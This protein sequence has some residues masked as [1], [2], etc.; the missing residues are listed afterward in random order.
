MFDEYFNPPTIAVSPVPVAAAPRAVDLADSPVSTSI[1]K[2]APSTTIPSIQDQEHSPIISQELKNFKQ[3]MIE[4]SWIDAMQE[5]IHEFERLQVWELVSCPDKVMLIKLKWIYKV[6]TDKF[7]WVLKNK[8]RLVAQGFRQEEGI[9]FEESFSSVAR[10]EAICI[11]VANADNKNMTI[12]QMDVKTAFLNGELKEEVYVSQPEGFIE[13]DNPSHVYKLKKALYGLKQAP[14]AWYDMLSSFLIS[15]HFSKGVVDLTLFTRKAGNDLLLVQIYVDIIIFASTNTAM[16][17]EFANLMTT[18]FKMS[19]IGQMSF[20]LGL[21]ISQS[22]RGIF[23]NQSKYASEI[24]KKYGMLT[25][26]SVDTPM[27]KPTEKHLNAVKQ[28]FRYLKGSINMGLLYL[29]DIGISLTA[30]V[31][32]DHARCQDTRCSTSRSAQFLG[33]KLVCWSSKKQKSTAISSTEAEYIALSRIMSSITAQQAKL[34][35]ELVPKEK[36]LEIGKCNGFRMDKKK[37]FSLNLETF[38]DIFQIFLRVHGQDFDELPT[39]EVTVSF[40]KE[41]GHTGEIKS[42]IDVVVDQ[43]HQPWRTFAT[44]INRSLSRKITGLDKLRLSRAQILWGMYYKKNVEYVELLWEDF[45]YQIDNRGHKKQEKMYYPRFTQVII[46]YFLT[47]DKTASRRNKIGMDTSRDDYL[48]NTLRFVSAN[49]ESQIYGARLP[50]S[51]TSPEMRETKAYKTYIGYATGVTP[52]KKARNFKKPASPKLTTVPASPKEPTKQSKRVKTPAKKSTNAPTTG[53]VIRDTPGVSVSK[54][55]APAKADRGK[56]IELLLDAALLEEAYIKKTLKKSKQETHKLQ[57]SVLSEGADFESEGDSDDD[58]ESDDNDDEGSENVDDSGNDAQDSKRTDSDEEDNPNL[59]LNVDE[60]EE[61]QEE[62]YDVNVRSKV[63]EHEEVGKG[64]VEMIDATRESGSQEK[65]Y[66]QVIEDAHVTLNTSQKNEGSKQSSSVSSDFASK[67]L[68]LDN[69]PPVVDEVASMMIVKVRQEE[70]STQAP[71]LHS[72]PVTAIPK[73]FIIP[74]TTNEL[75]QLKQVDHSTH[76]LTSIRSQIF[77]MVDDHLSTRIGFATQ[78]ALQSYS[79]KFEKKAQEEKDRY[80]DLIEKSIKDIIKDEVKSQLPL[81]IP[82]EVSD[83]ATLMIQSAINESLE[84]VILAKSSSQPKSPYKVAA[85][86]TEFELKNILLDKIEKSKSYQVAPEHKELYEALVKSYKLDKDL[87]DSYG[88]TYSLKRDR[89]DKDKDEGPSARSD[90]G[91]KKR[92][93]SKDVEP[94]KGPKT[95]ESKSNSSKGTKSQSKSSGKSAQAEEP[96]FKVADSDM[97]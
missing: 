8:A 28:I 24:I 23:L 67:F 43:M 86:F 12:F 15:Q 1:D 26:D 18:K 89:D 21:Q 71:P 66:E 92:K 94:T 49:E 20:F 4:P 91:L 22:P 46:H 52:L 81:I 29:K 95:K 47:K 3:A 31:D 38:K 75:S 56:G 10:I 77:V 9:D 73:T 68:I 57:V 58:N 35:L 6:K 14:R 54:K 13:Q 16:C 60:E 87:F 63:T 51:M 76:I 2:D 7:S 96:D 27:A 79:A 69:V 17:N 42:I 72:V 84:N 62:E 78:T 74:A 88:N 93:T 85:S 50:E 80:I 70:S 34:D 44:I 45:T 40:F 55:I 5:E 64:D 19:M 41:L 59:N 61:T 36:M 53:V 32:A 90:R 82:K 37:K 30:Y 25:S 48:I 11:F 33:D 39:D 83:F 65:S 97:P